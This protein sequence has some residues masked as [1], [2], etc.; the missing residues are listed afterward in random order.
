[1][2]TS[3]RRVPFPRSRGL[4]LEP[5]VPEIRAAEIDRAGD[6]PAALRTEGAEVVHLLEQG[7]KVV[8]LGDRDLVP[9]LEQ[10]LV[11]EGPAPRGGD[12]R[13]G[14]RIEGPVHRRQ[15]LELLADDGRALGVF[16][17]AGNDVRLG[18]G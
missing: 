17:E 12:V 18:G 3:R 4:L 14:G 9:E 8:R 15:E 11:V 2:S 13:A 1:M 6:A 10:A 7:R 16:F 5:H